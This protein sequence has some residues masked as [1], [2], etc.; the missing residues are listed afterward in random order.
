M[1]EAETTAA[2]SSV[3]LMALLRLA[4]LVATLS[5]RVDQIEQMQVDHSSLDVTR[6][7]PRIG[8]LE[9]ALRYLGLSNEDVKALVERQ[10][11]EI[12]PPGPSKTE[13][14]VV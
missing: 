6:A 4:D 14:K 9:R 8:D 10:K 13:G 2:K 7:H 3:D 5:A 1:S 12:P 11:K